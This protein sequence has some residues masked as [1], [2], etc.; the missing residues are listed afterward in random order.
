MNG[1]TPRPPGRT[2]CFRRRRR[3]HDPHL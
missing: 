3:R 1:A 2:T